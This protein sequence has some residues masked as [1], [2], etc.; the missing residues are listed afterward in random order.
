MP[1]EAVELRESYK[2]LGGWESLLIVVKA[3]IKDI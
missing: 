3:R 1:Q 2:G